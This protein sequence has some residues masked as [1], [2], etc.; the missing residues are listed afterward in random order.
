MTNTFPAQR[1]LS[2]LLWLIALHSCGVGILLI[3]RPAFLMAWAGFSL[4]VEPFFPVQNGVFHLVLAVGYALAAAP[5]L[6][7]RS[8][9]VFTVIVKSMAAIFLFSYYAIFDPRWVILWSG[10]G[11][12]AMAAAVWISLRAAERE[13]G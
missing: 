10:I 4:D 7:N 2:V 6:R 8:L 13:R 11:D 3:F 1:R 12:G 9:V 5:S